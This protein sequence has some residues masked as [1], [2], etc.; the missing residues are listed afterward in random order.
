MRSATSATEFM[1]DMAQP[2][3][4]NTHWACKL[5]S[6]MRQWVRAWVCNALNAVCLQKVEFML[7]IITYESQNTHFWRTAT[8]N[9]AKRLVNLST[10]LSLLSSKAW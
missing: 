10:C 6:S 4:S 9:L 8:P 3:S 7:I 2:K 1:K 5:S